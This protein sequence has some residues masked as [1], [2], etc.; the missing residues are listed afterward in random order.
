MSR[1]TVMSRGT[2]SA[3]NITAVNLRTAVMSHVLRPLHLDCL[4]RNGRCRNL[5]P[6]HLEAIAATGDS[7][8]SGLFSGTDSAVGCHPRSGRVSCAFLV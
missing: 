2:M 3:T 8:I 5:S 1:T 6:L 7:G 4:C